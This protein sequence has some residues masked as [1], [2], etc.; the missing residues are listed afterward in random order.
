MDNIELE[1]INWSKYNPRKDYKRPHWFAMSNRVL[2]DESLY[3]LSGDEFKAWVY[4]LCKASQLNSGSVKIYFKHAERVSGIERHV[5][6]SSIE[7]LIK[8]ECIRCSVQT[9][10]EICTDSVRHNTIQYNTIHQE[11]LRNSPPSAKKLPSTDSRKTI[12][13]SKLEDFSLIPTSYWCNWDDLYSH[14]FVERECRKSL[15]W[16]NANPKKSKKTLRGW[17]AFFSGW[18]DRSWDKSTTKGASNKTP[19]A[20]ILVAEALRKSGEWTKDRDLVIGILGEELF[21]R[22]IKIGV[23]R[24]RELPSGSFYL[25]NITGLLS[26]STTKG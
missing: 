4:I 24:F 22:C 3:E 17:V 16:L 23:R 15:I 21:N 2:E 12:E 1:I 13:I 18:F 25:K 8:A 10:N 11:L 7:K 14:E 6:S 26:E 5:L 9:T 19:N 20:A